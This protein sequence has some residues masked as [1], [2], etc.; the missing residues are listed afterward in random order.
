MIGEPTSG[1][2]APGSRSK[3]LGFTISVAGSLLYRKGIPLTLLSN[4][5]QLR[6]NFRPSALA[7]LASL[8]SRLWDLLA[9]EVPGVNVRQRISVGKLSAVLVARVRTDASCWCR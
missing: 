8:R 2:P 9:N 5:E 4:R 7:D 6:R 1:S 3:E